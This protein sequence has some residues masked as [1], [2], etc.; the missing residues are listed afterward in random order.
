M[1]G[2]MIEMVAVCLLSC[3]NN[4]EIVFS[5]YKKIYFCHFSKRIP[6]CRT[7]IW[8]K[9]VFE[10]VIAPK[11]SLPNTREGLLKGMAQYD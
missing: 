7:D 8:L 11:V 4:F 5:N 1:I 3:V 10:K 2:L 6:L 9:F